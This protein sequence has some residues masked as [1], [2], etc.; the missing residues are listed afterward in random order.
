M[1]NVQI[2]I[3]DLSEIQKALHGQ[4][5]SLS[6]VVSHL[7]KFNSDASQFTNFQQ[8]FINTLSG[9]EKMY[10]YLSGESNIW[11]ENI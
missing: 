1:S 7:E 6:A 8:Q 4:E 3:Q 11:L 10:G 9:V 5:K 2:E